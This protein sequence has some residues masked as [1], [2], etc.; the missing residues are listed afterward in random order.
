[1]IKDQKHSCGA[2]VVRL[3][4][5]AALLVSAACGSDGSEDGG[6][7][8]VGTAGTQNET[9]GGV[10]GASLGAGGLGPQSP[11]GGTGTGG[12]LAGAAPPGPTPGTQAA[13]DRSEPCT[14]AEYN[15]FEFV[16]WDTEI[17][18]AC[19]PN[20]DI[21]APVVCGGPRPPCICDATR[22]LPGE[23]AKTVSDE[24]CTCLNLC[25]GQSE[26]ARCGAN[27][28]RRCI[29]IDDNTGTQVFICGG[30]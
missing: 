17:R 28:E 18:R 8:R 25:S 13:S 27:A 24:F 22:C 11:T 6:P 1:M 14:P 9:T 16:E 21:W 2:R 26:D 15:S 20:Y 3:G 19:L 12:G 23:V 7:S 29:P 10:G 5:C 30:Q 4:A